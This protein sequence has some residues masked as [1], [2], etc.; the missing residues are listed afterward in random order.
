MAATAANEEQRPTEVSPRSL[1]QL[2]DEIRSTLARVIPVFANM[3]CGGEPRASD[4][5]AFLFD[6]ISS[7][8]RGW[9]VDRCLGGECM[10]WSSG[11]SR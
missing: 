9:L 7:L 10:Q 1:K 3:R 8:R 5:G 4:T 11:C 6:R 2:A